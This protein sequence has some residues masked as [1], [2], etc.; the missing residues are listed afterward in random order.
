MG[1]GVGDS[2]QG[3]VARFASIGMSA[4]LSDVARAV[5]QET[6]VAD[7]SWINSTAVSVINSLH[8]PAVMRVKKAD[9]VLFL[10]HC[11]RNAKECKAK[12]TEEGYQCAKCGKCPIA[13][14]TA[15]CEKAGIRP[16]VVGGGSAVIE[17]IKRHRPKAVIGVSCFPEAKLA[18]EKL[19]EYG[20]PVQSVILAKAGCVNTQ[21]NVSEVLEKIRLEETKA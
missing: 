16:F 8:K 15:E 1:L 21:V 18:I 12:I 5:A 9:R 19:A 7:E 14:I 10:P 13:A 2:I 11:L 6:R 20:I 3:I 17:I 4:S